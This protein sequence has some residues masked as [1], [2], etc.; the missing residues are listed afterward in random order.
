M[1]SP[2][3]AEQFRQSD[4]RRGLIPEDMTASDA[5]SVA[6]A[7]VAAAAK[8]RGEPAP[9]SYVAGPAQSAVAATAA[10]IILAGKKRRGEI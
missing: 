8:A 3:V 7:I 2:E 4:L 9:D 5:R 1:I 6:R 10:A